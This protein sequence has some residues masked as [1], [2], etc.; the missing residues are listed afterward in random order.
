MQ[1]AFK[2]N[3]TIHFSLTAVRAEK[4]AGKIYKMTIAEYE[5]NA[6]KADAPK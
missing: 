4:K 6:D 1:S 3:F 2:E 5:S